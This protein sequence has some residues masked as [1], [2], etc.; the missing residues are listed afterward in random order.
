MNKNSK[1]S[2]EQKLSVVRSV[3]SGKDSLTS[4]A[5]KMGGNDKSVQRWVNL[6][7]KYGKKGLELRNGTYDGE[8]KVRVIKYMLKKQLSLL[9]TSSFFGIP[10]DNSVG[11]WLKIYESLGAGGLL[12]ENRGR[13]KSIMAK[14]TKKSNKG[15]SNPKDEKL[16]AL[17]AENEYLRAELA[18]LKKLDALIQQE[19]AVKTQSRQQKP[20]RN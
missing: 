19:K 14:K 3:L 17:Q 1:Y 4:A 18:L 6:Y 8:F 13:K 12:L 20:S 9:Q 7:K 2:L 10:H 5:R 15:I 11:R 16:A